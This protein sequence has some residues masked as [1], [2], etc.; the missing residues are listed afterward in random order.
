MPY[1]ISSP[2]NII[3]SQTSASA[4]NGQYPFVER[5]ISG[6]NLF[7]VTDAN[8]NLTGST[9]IP[10]GGFTGSLFGTS[11]WASNALTASYLTTANSYQITNLTASN[12]S[13]S[14]S[15]SASNIW[16][17]NSFTYQ[18]SMATG[19][20]TAPDLY[21]SSSAQTGSDVLFKLEVGALTGSAVAMQII[22]TGSQTSYAISASAGTIMSI[23]G[24]RRLMTPTSIMLIHQLST[25]MGGKFEEIKDDYE[26]SEQDM[27]RIISLYLKE[28]NGK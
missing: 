26:N 23:A 4:V 16:I 27:K 3:I 10:G 18:E 24:K 14:N 11:S 22:A 8:G 17:Y 2:L 13:A 20:L 7:I 28:S 9:S 25:G 1:P 12:I 5:I 15:L 21:F 19:S 6:S